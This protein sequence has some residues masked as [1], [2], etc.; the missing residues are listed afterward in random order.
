ML[1]PVGF[2]THTLLQSSAHLARKKESGEKDD[3]YRGES[4]C[5][6]LKLQWSTKHRCD[7]RGISSPLINT[8]RNLSLLKSEQHQDPH[9]P[10]ETDSQL[11]LGQDKH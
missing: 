5:Q 9:A 8:E 4:N 7:W 11:Q 2:P 3:C 1:P 6:R 10:E